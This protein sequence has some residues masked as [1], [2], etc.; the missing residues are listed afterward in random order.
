MPS[1]AR[2]DDRT[3]AAR[4][5]DAAIEVVAAQG[6]AALTARAVA[7]E[8]GVSAGSVIHHFGSMDGLR[9]ACDEHV[10]AVIREQKTAAL[11]SG[12]GV[13]VTALMRDQRIVGLVGYLAAALTDES[14]AVNSL[15]D[16]LVAD[17]EQ[18]V[19]QGVQSGMLRPSSNPR[20]RAVVLTLWGL[21]PLVMRRHL[22]RL[23]GVDL[24]EHQRDP[25]TA[26]LPY[27]RPVFELFSA[28][29]YTEE[30]ASSLE[31][32][33]GQRSAGGKD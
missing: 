31:P 5:R 23:L 3:T 8:A 33:L 22:H 29:L 25:A 30:L 4:I 16:D 21:A 9:A 18:Y 17:A 20:A 6:T 24:T 26:L 27:M 7:E 28:G 11:R 14:S 1:R 19:E 15:V 13:D 2:P 10:V 12:P 32:V